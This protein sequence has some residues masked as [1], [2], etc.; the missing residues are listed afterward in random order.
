ME[1]RQVKSFN[2][3]FHVN[4]SWAL[5][6]TW[7][8]NHAMGFGTFTRDLEYPAV[9]GDSGEVLYFLPKCKFDNIMENSKKMF[10][11]TFFFFCE[12]EIKIDCVF[13]RT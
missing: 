3:T 9:L 4:A 5:K 7:K 12:Y 6:I 10:F 2:K 13:N 8:R 11:N 1:E